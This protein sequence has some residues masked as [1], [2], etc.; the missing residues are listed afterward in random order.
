MIYD[1]FPFF[2]EVE[3]LEVR[4]HELDP[5]VDRFVLAE[6]TRT[7]SNQPK[8]LHFQENRARFERFLPKITHVV[9]DDLPDT[10]DAWRLEGFQRAAVARGLAGCRPDDLILNSDVDEIPR[11]TAIEELRR[12][13]RYRTTAL[14]KLGHGLLRRPWSVR[15]ARNLF[16][17]RHPFVWVLEQRLFYFQLNLESSSLP[18]W[19]GTRAMFFRDFTSACDLR[20]WDGHRVPH[21]GWHFS[22]M[23]GADRVRQKL[24]AYA[25]QEYN[26]PEHTDLQRIQAALQDGRWLLGEEHQLQRVPLDE[27]FPRFIRQNRDQFAHWIKPE[28]PTRNPGQPR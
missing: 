14:A 15:L 13:L 5:V 26:R 22:Y 9:V 27:S 6:A 23:G 16:K 11:A 28:T 21:G 17:K 19:P 4:L 12:R 8:P 24:Q 25:H 2:N 10:S 1:T 20:R 7:H 18:A 3:L